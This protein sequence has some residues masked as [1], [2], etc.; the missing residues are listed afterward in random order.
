MGA[1]G[2]E[3]VTV[4]V[5]EL[6]ASTDKAIQVLDTDA[7]AAKP[8]WFPKSVVHDDSE[9]FGVGSEGERQKAGERGRLVLCRWWVERNMPDHPSL[10]DKSR[11]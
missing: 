5:V 10:R 1:R 8:R 9:I 4:G 3:A 2:D 11:E 7:D 6:L